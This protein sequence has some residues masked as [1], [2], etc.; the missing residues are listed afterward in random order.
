ML[1][2][3]FGFAPFFSK[4]VLN[5]FLL[6]SSFILWKI[7][8]IKSF[9][10]QKKPAKLAGLKINNVKHIP[11]DIVCKNSVYTETA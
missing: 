1:K 10:A 6:I 2:F 7:E 9:Q 11:V 8:T 4:S 5:S 3:R